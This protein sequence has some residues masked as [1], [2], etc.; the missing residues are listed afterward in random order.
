MARP[1]TY[2]SIAPPTDPSGSARAGNYG[3]GVI[4]YNDCILGF[5][6]GHSGGLPGYG[7]N[8]LFLPDRGLGLFAFANRTYAPVARVVRD[9]AVQLVKSDSFPARALPTSEGLK[10]MAIAVERIYAA[11]DVLAAHDAL[12]MNVLLDR[13]AALRNNQ[14]RELKGQLGACRAADPIRADTAMSATLTFPCANGTLRARIILAPTTPPSMQ[15][16]EFSR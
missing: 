16:L 15:T 11:G 4:V 10:A 2:A 12:A 6:F 14:L 13:S 7:S 1:Q 8:V 3:F 9:A 5:H